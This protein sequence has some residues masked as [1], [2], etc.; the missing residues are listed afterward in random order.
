RE[1]AYS[2]GNRPMRF[3]GAAARSSDVSSMTTGRAIRWAAA[4]VATGA[5]TLAVAGLTSAGAATVAAPSAGDP[6]PASTSSA[7]AV[8][9]VDPTPSPAPTPTVNALP[10][11]DFV[12]ASGVP[13]AGRPVTFTSTS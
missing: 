10:V 1:R 5:M 2:G 13:V 9:V 3:G 8:A 11:A 7:Q 4:A 12:V 6:A